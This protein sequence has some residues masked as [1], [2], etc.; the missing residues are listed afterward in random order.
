MVRPNRMVQK[1]Q[2]A[3]TLKQFVNQ[4]QQYVSTPDGMWTIKG[5][6]DAYRNIYAISADT[7]VVSKIM[8]IHLL[9]LLLEYA[10]ENGYYIVLAEHQN[11]Y[12][13]MSFVDLRHPGIKFAVDLKTTHR[14]P[15]YPGHI[16]GFTLGSHGEYFK[17]R[18]STKNVQFPYGDYAGHFCIGVI[19]TRN[20]SNADFVTPISIDGLQSITSVISDFQFF[21]CEKWQLASDRRGSGNTANIGSITNIEDI[22]TDN[23]VFSNLG[24]KWFDEYWINY[25]AATMMREGESIKITRLKDFIEFKGGDV[26][27][28]V[29]MRTK[30][31]RAR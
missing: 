8:E 3:E 20:D 11:W 29:P 28:I 18:T 21:A 31:R 14:L 23:G 25:G 4:M 30:S 15:D 9:P 12:P 13:D 19:Y 10:H 22:L 2:F 26:S 6:I 17:N 24:E 7:K 16:N 5:F 1:A 27:L